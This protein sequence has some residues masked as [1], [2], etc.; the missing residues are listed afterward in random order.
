[1]L[2]DLYPELDTWDDDEEDRLEHL[3]VLKARGKGAPKKRRTREGM[4]G[5][6]CRRFVLF[7]VGEG[8]MGG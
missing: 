1:M 5:C 6:Y 2:T 3:E 4:F 7:F 8:E